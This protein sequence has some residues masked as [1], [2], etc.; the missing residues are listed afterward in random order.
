MITTELSFLKSQ[1]CLEQLIERVRQSGKDGHQI[2]ENRTGIVCGPD[3]DGL[4]SAQRIC[5]AIG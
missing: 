2:D 3:A 5:Q 4:L 1:D